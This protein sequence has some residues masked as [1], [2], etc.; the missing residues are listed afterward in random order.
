MPSALL[1]RPAATVSTLAARAARQRPDLASAFADDGWVL[2]RIED[3]LLT[4]DGLAFAAGDLALARP[5]VAR[6][7]GDFIVYSERTA[8]LAGLR[9]GDHFAFAETA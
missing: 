6:H 8:S 1:Q 3:T 2:V 4:R 5:A 9:H 7:A